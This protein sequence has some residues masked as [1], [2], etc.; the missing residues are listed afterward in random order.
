MEIPMSALFALF[1]ATAACTSQ[2]KLTSV[3]PNS[4]L[5]VLDKQAAMLEVVSPHSGRIR[6]RLATG[7]GPHEVAV[8]ADGRRAVVTNYGDETP[9]NSL[10]VYDLSEPLRERTIDLGR[11]TRPHGVQFLNARTKVVVTAEATRSLLIV[12]VIKG[13]VERAIDT[14]GAV[15]HMLALTPDR[16][17]CFVAN[18]QSG[19]VS[20]IDLEAGQ[21]VATI[22]TGNVPE[23]LAVSPDGKELWVANR[24]D[25][26]LVII[27]TTELEVVATLG[28]GKFPIR[29]AFTPDGAS[30]LVSNAHDGDVAVFDAK[31]RE[32]RNRI[33]I[34]FEAGADSGERLFGTQFGGSPVPIG[35]LIEP[36]GGYAFVAL[37]NADRVVVIDL[38]SETVTGVIATG[39][40]PDG[41]GWSQ[42]LRRPSFAG[43]SE[44]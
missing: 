38:V 25:D 33:A 20:V 16:E 23:G 26:N 28:T 32:L 1:L 29:V 8:S 4:E 10:S 24:A 18:M 12:D 6:H 40:E 36:R 42:R 13:E 2:D 35:I 19:S 41:L 37:A 44:D 30:V 39:P 3:P 5:I 34:D 14:G 27:D 9:G 22:A 7:D 31:A 11:H 21:L 17:R 15:S 43:D